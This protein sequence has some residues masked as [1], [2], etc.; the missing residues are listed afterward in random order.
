METMSVNND[1]MKKRILLEEL[2]RYGIQSR[3]GPSLEVPEHTLENLL[4]EVKN[5]KA[6]SNSLLNWFMDLYDSMIVDYYTKLTLATVVF[7]SSFP[8]AAFFWPPYYYYRG[9]SDNHT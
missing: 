1:T 8:W 2:E 9:K 5:K 6:T 4:Q 7:F 3:A